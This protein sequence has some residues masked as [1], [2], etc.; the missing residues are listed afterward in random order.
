MHT[1]ANDITRRSLKI[2]DVSDEIRTADPVSSPAN[3]HSA[4]S[5]GHMSLSE[6]HSADLTAADQKNTGILDDNMKAQ[7]AADC[8]DNHD[9][10]RVQ[11]GASCG[12]EY[13]DRAKR[14]GKLE[15]LSRIEVSSSIDNVARGGGVARS[16]FSEEGGDEGEA[17]GRARRQMHVTGREYERQARNYDREADLSVRYLMEKVGNKMGYIQNR[18]SSVEEGLSDGQVSIPRRNVES[19]F[20]NSPTTE[21][22]GR[23]SERYKEE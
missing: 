6:T 15:E 10:S 20:A 4:W 7:S 16:D 5:W 23:L 18:D 21:Q 17:G 13:D 14:Q 22:R 2:H 12:S 8:Q 9:N 1:R 3:R 19:C 11:G